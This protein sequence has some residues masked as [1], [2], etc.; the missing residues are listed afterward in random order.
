MMMETKNP[1]ANF[2]ETKNWKEAVKPI[3]IGIT[4][5]VIAQF[6]MGNYSTHNYGPQSYGPQSYGPQA[7]Q[8]GRP[9]GQPGRPSGQTWNGQQCPTPCGPLRLFDPNLA[10][11]YPYNDIYTDGKECFH[12][13]GKWITPDEIAQW[14]GQSAQG[15]KVAGQV[16]ETCQQTTDI[17]N[18]GYAERTAIADNSADN[19]AESVRGT[20]RFNYNGNTY[21][22]D[23]N[24]KTYAA[25]P[26][27]RIY[28]SDSPGS[29]DGNYQILELQ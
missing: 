25:G 4:I 12:R 17:M 23:D 20:G 13:N 7:G 10:Q 14:R 9:A 6:L 3:A 16:G 2:L 28:Y 29:F 24:T 26:D 19:Y 18:R 22:V 1:V 11:F 15:W 21:G 5:V 27:G 8:P